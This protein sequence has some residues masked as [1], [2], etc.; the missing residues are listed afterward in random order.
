MSP[1][2]YLPVSESDIQSECDSSI[3]SDIGQ[4]D[5]NQSVFNDSVQPVKPDKISAALSLPTVATY[6]CRSL[7][8][9]IDSLK[10]DLLERQIDVSFLTEIWEQNHNNDH[11]Y[12]IET[13]L[14]ISELQYISSARPPNNLHV[15]S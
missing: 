12:E 9:K 4:L 5:G 14:E 13:M 10:T 6:N 11:K 7:F 2:N 8:P 1:P 3:L 15:R